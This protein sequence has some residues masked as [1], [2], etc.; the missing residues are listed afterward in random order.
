MLSPCFQL[1][2][3]RDPHKMVLSKYKLPLKQAL[4]NTCPL[5][6][7]ENCRINMFQCEFSSSSTHIIKLISNRACAPNNAYTS[8]ICAMFIIYHTAVTLPIHF[9]QV[10]YVSHSPE[11]YDQ[12][13]PPNTLYCFYKA[14][15]L[16]FDDL[17]F[18]KYAMWAN[19]LCY[20][21]CES[22]VP[23]I[24]VFGSAAVAYNPKQHQEVIY[25][26]SLHIGFRWFCHR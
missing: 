12:N 5:R 3:R 17:A 23:G 26:Y 6:L 14:A 10:C 20:I 1:A 22:E 7:K 13:M 18:I 25:L 2:S 11:C 24:L 9:L 4:N 15:L 21:K 19:W 8:L 16:E